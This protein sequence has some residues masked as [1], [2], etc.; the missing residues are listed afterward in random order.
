[1]TPLIKEHV[2]SPGTKWRRLVKDELELYTY[3]TVDT[4][5]HR[6]RA[7][8]MCIVNQIVKQVPKHEFAHGL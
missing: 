3:I 2:L 8:F 6:F 5:L 7:G 1:M 4:T